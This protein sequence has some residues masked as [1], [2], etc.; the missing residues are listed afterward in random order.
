MQYVLLAILLVCSLVIVVAVLFQKSGEKGLSGTISGNSETYYGKD[1]TG[2]REKK[3]FKWTLIASIVFA[4]AVVAV[5]VIQPDYEVYS[6]YNTVDAW[7][8]DSSLNAFSS[9]FSSTSK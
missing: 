8:T 6:S 4:I 7:Q 3:L 1:K 9:I 2:G 5:Y